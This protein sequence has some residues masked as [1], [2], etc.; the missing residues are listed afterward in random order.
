MIVCTAGHIDHGKTALVRALTGI[1]ADRLAEEKA[2]GITID[3]GFAYLPMA[4]GSVMGFVDVP[5]HERFVHNMLA[6]VSGLDFALLV[7]AADDGVMPQTVEHLHILDLLGLNRGLVALTKAD[8]VPSERLVEAEAEITALLAPTALAGIPIIPVSSL[9]GLGIDVVAACL[10]DNASRPQGESQ[11]LFRLAVDRAF[12]IAGAGVVVTGTAFAGR[13]AAGARLMLSPSGREVRIRSLHA[14]NRKAESGQA[15]QRLAL[16]LAATQLAK[17]DIERGEWVIDPALHHPVER[18]DCTFRLL[19]G[20]PRPLAHWTPVHLH[21]AA[22]HVPARIALLQGDSLAAGDEALVQLVLDRPI[23]ALAGDRFILRDQSAQRT[24]GGGRV[25]DIF[26]PNRGRRTAARLAVLAIQQCCDPDRILAGLLDQAP[27]WVD[28]DA[29]RQQW[30]RP[31]LAVPGMVQVGRFAFAAAAWTGLRTRLVEVLAAHHQANPDQPGLQGPRLKSALDPKMPPDLF[32]CVLSAALA[33]DVLSSDGPWYRLPGHQVRLSPG[34]EALWDEAAPLLEAERFRPPRVR[35]LAETLD[36]AEA[37]MR[38]LMKRLARMGQ[39]VLVAQDHYFLRPVMAEM[40]AILAECAQA[41]AD[42]WVNAAAFRD[43]LDN[44]RKVAIQILEYFDRV[45]LTI[46][47]GDLRKVRMDRLALFGGQDGR[48][49][50]PV[51]RTDFKSGNGRSP[52][53]GGFDSHSLPPS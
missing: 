3:L 12:T 1:D 33:D 17:D 43:R 44:G 52:A 27:G 8:L 25:I 41:A 9:T 34:D 31:D 15:G 21:L 18:F 26:P 42:G 7:V 50:S 23:G 37:D 19:P 49:A 5:G 30:N 13:V 10:A 22:A 2:R 16:N 36:V 20:E 4:D 29:Q 46:R 51:G 11:G 48:E 47:K 28:L 6:G 14:Q 32:A 38:G 53:V 24:M 40:A 45:G 39:V 35:D